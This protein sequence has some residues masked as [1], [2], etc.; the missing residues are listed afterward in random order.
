ME[1]RNATVT[2]VLSILAVAGGA[3]IGYADSQSD[4]VFIT[5]ALLMG[6]SALLGLVG[7]RRPWLWAPL[8]AIWVPV[9]D[10]VLPRLGLAPQ[11]PGESFTFLSALAVTGL[12]MAVSFA[13][14]YLGAGLVWAAR[15]AWQ[16]AGEAQ[17]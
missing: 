12:V 14:A 3:W 10:S 7:P 13:G 1:S 5:L 4:D 11:R 8:V 15:H 2:V 6:F 9:L 16:G 17:R